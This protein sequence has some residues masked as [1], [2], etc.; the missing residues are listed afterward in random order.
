[1]VLNGRNPELILNCDR[2]SVRFQTWALMHLERMQAVA[3]LLDKAHKTHAFSKAVREQKDKITTPEKTRSARILE[4]MGN[5]QCSFFQFAMAKATEHERFFRS[6]PLPKD[7]LRLFQ[8]EAVRSLQQQSALE[9]TDTLP[10]DAYI[11]AYFSPRIEQ[12]EPIV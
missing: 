2:N 10:L 3:E 6:R 12:L 8:E 5:Q 1:M 7:K 9:A 4:E 11:A